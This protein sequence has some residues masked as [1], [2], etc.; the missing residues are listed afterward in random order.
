MTAKRHSKI[1]QLNVTVCVV[2]K[3][4][5]VTTG[6]KTATLIVAST[7]RFG[8]HPILQAHLVLPEFHI[9]LGFASH[10]SALLP[11][12]RTINGGGEQCQAILKP[13]ILIK[14][15]TDNWIIDTPKRQ[16][17]ANDS[18]GLTTLSMR[19]LHSTISDEA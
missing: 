6:I 7:L 11:Q 3:Y 15:S 1:G 5:P 14:I 2:Q 8:R 18:E 16:E 13:G 10:F 19:Y 12:K 17:E 9:L 4:V